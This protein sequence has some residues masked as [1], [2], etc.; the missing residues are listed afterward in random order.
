MKSLSLFGLVF[1]L[2]LVQVGCGTS[3]GSQSP[4]ASIDGSHFLLSEEPEGAVSVIAARE[5]A[6][7]GTPIVLMG[8]VGGTANPWIEGR[9]A[10]MLIDPSVSVVA[11]G[12]DS[13]EGEICLDDCC[14]DERAG[15]T[16]LVKVVDTDGNIVP[17]DARQLLGLK[18]SDLVVVQGTAKK[19][20]SGNFSML[21]TKVFVRN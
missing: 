8:R 17:V 12:T 11:N 14:A 15:C 21:A 20:K 3:P 1:V 4:G 7:D 16:S 10:F 13:T 2:G 5:S 9:A 6:E 18:E 19:D